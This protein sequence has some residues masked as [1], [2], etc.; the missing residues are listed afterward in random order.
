MVASCGGSHFGFSTAAAEETDPALKA[1]YMVF[2]DQRAVMM[3]ELQEIAG[4]LGGIDESAPEMETASRRWK[5]LMESAS[6]GNTARTIEVCMRA[7]EGAVNTYETG[8]QEDDLPKSLVTI[9]SGHL[10]TFEQTRD[11]LKDLLEIRMRGN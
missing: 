3:H 11:K 1:L 5:K 9:A 6:E 7:E 10:R 8:L 2:R 4:A